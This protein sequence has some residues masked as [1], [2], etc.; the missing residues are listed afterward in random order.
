MPYLPYFRE[1]RSS[2]FLENVGI[3]LRNCTVECHNLTF[4]C[5]RVEVLMVVEINSSPQ[6]YFSSIF[7]FTNA[8][9]IE[10]ADSSEISV[11]TYETTARS[12]SHR[13]RWYRGN[14]IH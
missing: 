12:Q 10:L 2:W 9:E 8:L 14:R 13:T 7:C 3:D 6:G 1:V 5:V 11:I 4:M